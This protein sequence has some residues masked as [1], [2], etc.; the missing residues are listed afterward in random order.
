MRAEQANNEMLKQQLIEEQN[1]YMRECFF[2]HLASKES[3]MEQAK[4]KEAEEERERMIFNDHK[5]RRGIIQQ[6]KQKEKQ[7]AQARIQGNLNVKLGNQLKEQEKA[8]EELCRRAV[9]E[10]DKKIEAAHKAKQIKAQ[11]GIDEMKQRLR[12]QRE[13]AERQRQE[14]LDAEYIEKRGEMRA[15]EEHRQRELDRAKE[16]KDIA[17]TFR[18]HHLK[19]VNA[20]IARQRKEHELDLACDETINK[21]NRLEEKEFLTYARD[22]IDETVKKGKIIRQVAH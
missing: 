12:Q 3:L 18:D 4:R 8:T 10:A 16:R 5:R 17:I 13:E 2:A 21:L 1:N 11:K 15:D 22:V 14:Q 20:T 19:Q 7:E 9:I 6:Q